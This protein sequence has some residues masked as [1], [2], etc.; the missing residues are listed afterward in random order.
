MRDTPLRGE[1]LVTK[2]EKKKNNKKKKAAARRAAHATV[3]PAGSAAPVRSEPGPES[4]GEGTGGSWSLP[5]KIGLAIGAVAALVG[6][7]AALA[8]WP[9]VSVWIWPLL[10]SPTSKTI[11]S[12][13]DPYTFPLFVEN[14]SDGHLEDV[15]LLVTLS[16]SPV[17]P[18]HFFLQARTHEE[19]EHGESRDF[20]LGSLTVGWDK[21]GKSYMLTRIGTLNAHKRIDFDA[22]FRTPG[23]S[24]ACSRDL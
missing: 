5:T 4:E 1:D 22:H 23:E 8:A 9:I 18:G 20:D 19:I 21:D 3:Q 11:S 15:G 7:V 13:G 24:L 10:I 16:P 6:A 17:Q 12:A 14:R 2:G